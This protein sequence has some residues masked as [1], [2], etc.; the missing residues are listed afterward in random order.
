MTTMRTVTAVTGD[1][2]AWHLPTT[3]V[4]IHWGMPCPS[5]RSVD[6]IDDQDQEHDKIMII[7]IMV[8]LIRTM[9]YAK[10]HGDDD[11]DYS[12]PKLVFDFS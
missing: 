2:R 1:D 8:M 10:D 7:A 5:A 4:P 9:M 3:G 6:D 12:L 11:D